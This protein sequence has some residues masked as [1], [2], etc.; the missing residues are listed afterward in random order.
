MY[1]RRDFVRSLAL[2][3]LGMGAGSL[4]CSS[5]ASRTAPDSAEGGGS[6]SPAP[7][8]VRTVGPQH[9]GPTCDVLAF[10]ADPALDDNQPAIQQAID[11]CEANG[12]GI[13]SLP[14]GTFRIR[15]PLLVPAG[16]D[17]VLQGQ[18][19]RAT[20]LR[21]TTD[22][23]LDARPRSHRG[24]SVSDAFDVDAIVLVDHADDDFNDYGA[25]RDLMLMGRGQE[26]T[27]YG[28]YA[29][30]LSRWTVRDVQIQSVGRGFFSHQLFLTECSSVMAEHVGEGFV[31][32][33]DGS[34]DGGSTSW[35]LT[36]CYVNHARRSGYRFFGLDY[37]SLVS[38]AADDVNQSGDP[39][40]AAYRVSYGRGVNL[41]G[42]GCEAS[43]GHVIWFTRGIGSV[44]GCRTVGV[45]G[46]AGE[47]SAYLRW[48]G[49]DVVVSGC[50]F[51]S[52]DEAGDSFNEIV[53]GGS[54][55]T[56]VET[57]RPDG[58]DDR[59]GYSGGSRVKTIDE[60]GVTIRDARGEVES[61]Y[62]R[63]P[64]PRSAAYAATG[65]PGKRTLEVERAGNDDVVAVLATLISDL[66]ETGILGEA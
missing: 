31:L 50:S 1:D 10:G 14:S 44:N 6:A 42:C 27:T 38:C 2:P 66:Q 13:V 65:S 23:V 35:S 59:I 28:L 26:R 8:A 18:G 52:F 60:Q 54:Q 15:K 46:L 63:A 4:G 62:G 40:A 24:G 32:A 16:S 41:V 17:V 22:E 19:R 61:F 58:G 49:S 57:T 29:P 48:E 20:M 47:R 56:Y 37:S 33:D 39:G 34:G 5:L 36:N 45:R 9:A 12:G 64:R 3:A 55:V 11:T 21:K 51:A 43:R 25:L 53:E 7:T 30:R